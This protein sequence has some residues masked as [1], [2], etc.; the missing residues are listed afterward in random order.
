MTP[1]ARYSQGKKEYYTTRRVYQ[2]GFL[3]P[4]KFDVSVIYMYQWMHRF[5]D[6]TMAIIRN[7]LLI[8]G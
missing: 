3:N 8:L 5:I 6:R 4:L 2:I 7:L 1:F